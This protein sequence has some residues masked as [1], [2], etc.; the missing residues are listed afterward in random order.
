MI[1]LIG[2][3]GGGKSTVARRLAELGALVR[4]GPGRSLLCADLNATP[5]SPHFGDLLRDAGLRDARRGFGHQPTWP[6]PLGA[7][8]RIPIDHCLVSA[9]IAVRDLRVTAPI[10]SDHLPVVVDLE[11]TGGE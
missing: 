11:L 5:W 8:A 3:I 10:G 4:A 7:A 2:S 9:G 1:G 6:A